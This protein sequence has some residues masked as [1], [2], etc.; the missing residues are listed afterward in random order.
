MCYAKRQ[1]PF[2]QK[3]TEIIRN[4]FAVQYK[5]DFLLHVFR[6]SHHISC[7]T[8]LELLNKGYEVVVYDN[9]CNSSQESLRRVEELTGKKVA[10]YDSIPMVS[11]QT[12]QLLSKLHSE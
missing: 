6:S 12:L 11:A 4:L 1:L 2:C 8:A 9:L 5:L 7:H 3:I 10:F